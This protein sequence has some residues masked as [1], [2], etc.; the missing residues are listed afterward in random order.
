MSFKSDPVQYPSAESTDALWP[1]HFF[2]PPPQHT[3]APP[4]ELFDQEVAELDLN[5]LFEQFDGF[6]PTSYDSIPDIF[7][8]SALTSST[9]SQYSS[10]FTQSDYSIPSEIES[11]YSSD[12]GLYGM[13]DSIHS[14]VPS[15]GP[16]S[17]P[18]L[19]PA[20]PQFDFGTLDLTPDVGISPEVLSTAMQP[21][22]PVHVAPPLEAQVA[23]ASDRPFKC[24]LCPHC[25]AETI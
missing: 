1:E 22:L 13:H 15:N 12:N 9:D 25:K 6:L 5:F 7:T 18:L 8:P 20:E 24:P 3:D 14:A 2:A 11:Y 19:H 16:P 4:P 17:I 21:P 23:P 10:D